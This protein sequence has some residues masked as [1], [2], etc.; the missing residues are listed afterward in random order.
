MSVGFYRMRRHQQRLV[1]ARGVDVMGKS[2]TVYRTRLDYQVPTV[3][4]PVA[5]IE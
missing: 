3:V 5:S 4:G 1:R 2:V